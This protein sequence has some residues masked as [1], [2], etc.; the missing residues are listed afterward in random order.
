MWNTH[1]A[2]PKMCTES[3]VGGDEEVEEDEG[4]GGDDD[5]TNQLFDYLSLGEQI[6]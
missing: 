3:Y 1:T 2:Y 6:H 5:W 4:G